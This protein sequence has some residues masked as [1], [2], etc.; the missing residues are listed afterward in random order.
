MT[1]GPGLVPGASLFPAHLV[2]AAMP[3]DAAADPPEDA[4]RHAPLCHLSAAA[5]LLVPL[6]TV[7][8]PLV[9]W[10][11][12]KEEDPFVDEQGRHAVDVNLAFL[13]LELVLAAL[14]V[15][16]AFLGLLD[17]LLAAPAFVLGAVLAGVVGLA[18]A[19]VVLYATIEVSEGEDVR[20]PF[21]LPLM[22]EA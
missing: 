1:P 7:L 15:A 10:I 21:H 3:D 22:A 5:G 13:V 4:R 2:A 9:A 19:A 16:W 12:F 6:G 14:F 8:G 20:I 18:H 17:P 11:L